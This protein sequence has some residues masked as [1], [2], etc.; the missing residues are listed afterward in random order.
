ME[1]NWK[2][3]FKGEI[4][5]GFDL[6]SVKREFAQL[7]RL[8]DEQARKLFAGKAVILKKELP[9]EKAEQYKQSFERRGIKVSLEQESK[10]VEVNGFTLALQPTEEQNTSESNDDYNNGKEQ[11]SGAG[12]KQTK[13]KADADFGSNG[14]SEQF[15][16]NYYAPG[17]VNELYSD[18]DDDVCVEAPPIFSLSFEGRYGRCNFANAYLLSAVAGFFAGIFMAF[19]PFGILF[20]LI[21]MVVSI[22]YG[23]RLISLRLHDLNLSGWYFLLVFVILILL[24]F[25]RHFILF[26]LVYFA[27]LISLFAYPGKPYSNNYG[28]P[29]EQ[30]HPIGIILMGVL[31][32]IALCV[33]M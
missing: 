18:E 4:L 3:I 1:S 6:D 7:L 32:M 21:F 16:E 10:T 15:N 28:P 22:V 29:A 12:A 19:L 24:A 20:G 31:M 26:T 8:N 30:G 27:C 5:P 14:E 33:H 13:A 23:V 25:G 17:G 11:T 9:L 2:I